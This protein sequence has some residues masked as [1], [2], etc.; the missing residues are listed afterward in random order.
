MESI[1]GLL[2][3]VDL[4][5]DQAGLEPELISHHAVSLGA[6]SEHVVLVHIAANA[7]AWVPLPALFP[8]KLIPVFTT[9]LHI[10]INAQGQETD[11]GETTH[12]RVKIK[13]LI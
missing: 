8:T 4:F 12:G 10:K 2:S 11:R 6:A 3:V 5:V 13:A 7:F 1:L 9:P